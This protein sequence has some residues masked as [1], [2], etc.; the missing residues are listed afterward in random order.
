MSKDFKLDQHS[1][2][3]GFVFRASEVKLS[4]PVRFGWITLDNTYPCRSYDVVISASAVPEAAS[5]PP[6]MQETWRDRPP[7][8]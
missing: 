1:E 5:E 6:P 4:G 2:K 8:L 3:F 7:M